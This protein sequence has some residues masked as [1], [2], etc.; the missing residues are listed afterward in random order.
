MTGNARAQEFKL[1]LCVDFEIAGACRYDYGV[2]AR[3]RHGIT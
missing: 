3:E 2:A 1:P